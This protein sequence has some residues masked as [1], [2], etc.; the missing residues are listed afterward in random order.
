MFFFYS[1]PP[2]CEYLLTYEWIARVCA[3]LIYYT[4]LYVR[5][6]FLHHQMALKRSHSPPTSVISL[7]AI[8]LIIIALCGFRGA[9]VSFS[10]SMDLLYL[11]PNDKLNSSK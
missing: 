4:V 11:T 10:H 3:N 7:K 1:T 2:L 9:P 6:F 5:Q 8:V